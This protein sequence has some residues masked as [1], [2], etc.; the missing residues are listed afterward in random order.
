VLKGYVCDTRP[1]LGHNSIDK[2]LGLQ[3]DFYFANGLTIG[4]SNVKVLGSIEGPIFK[5]RL[6]CR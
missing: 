3:L 6:A 1:N 5:E 2:Y 4:P